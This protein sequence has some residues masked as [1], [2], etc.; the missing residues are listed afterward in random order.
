MSAIFICHSSADS[1]IASRVRDVLEKE[2]HRS[3]FLDFDPARGIP[4]GRDWE[5]ELYAQLRACRACVVLAARRRSARGNL[6]PL[7]RAGRGAVSIDAAARRADAR[8]TIGDV[9]AVIRPHGQR[10]DESARLFR[11][12]GGLSTGLDKTTTYAGYLVNVYHYARHSPQVISLA[13]SRAVQSNR[14][15]AAY[16]MH[17]GTEEIAH[18]QWASSDLSTWG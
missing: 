18:E 15:P 9:R 3:V 1:E 10:E 5:K 7:E 4:A 13:A 17:H 2:G 6:R 12:R 14:E 8:Q 11:P 16:L